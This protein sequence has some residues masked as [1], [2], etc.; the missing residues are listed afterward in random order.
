M[1]ASSQSNWVSGSN[2]QEVTAQE[3]KGADLEK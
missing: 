2:T 3:V 1:E